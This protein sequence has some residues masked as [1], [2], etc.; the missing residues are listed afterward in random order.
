M[1]QLL[2]ESR[3]VARRH[4]RAVMAI[5][6][7]LARASMP[8]ELQRDPN[9]I[10][11]PTTVAELKALVPAFAFDAYFKALAAPAF[12]TLNVLQPDFFKALDELLKTTSMADIRAYLRWHLISVAAPYLSSAFVD[13]RFAFFGK[14]M[15]GLKE[16]QPRWKR[17]VGTVDGALGEAIGQIYVARYFPPEARARVLGMIENG[18]A[19]MRVAIQEAEWLSA[20]TKEK[21]LAKLDKTQ[22][23]IGY[24]DKWRDYTALSIDRCSYVGNVLRAR[25][26]AHRLDLDK[27]GKPVDRSQWYMTP[28]T[29]NA[30]A[31]PQSNEVA[32]PAAIL[33]PPFFDF[34]ADDAANYGGILVVILHEFGHLFDDSGANYDADGNV[35]MQWTEQDFANFMARVQLIRNQF[36]RFTVGPNNVHLKGD[37]VSGE[38]AADLNGVVLSYRALQMALAKTGRKV[39]A[40]GFTDE[41]RFFIAFGQI[42]AS[43]ST[44]E[45]AEQQAKTDPHPNEQFRVNGTLAH[46]AEFPKAFGLPDD[47]PIM[48]PPAERCHIW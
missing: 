45:Y 27:I 32:F 23:K 2:G 13:E 12:D 47:C 29:V 41:Q 44:P 6:T 3:A 35:N 9:N 7:A 15:S 26:F 21:L 16:Q 25:Q 37:L 48:L 42:W 43:I 30:Y 22:W 1:F 34:E 17:V 33:Q 31:D 18:K 39:D 10:H 38:A 28:Q 4:A 14:V 40:N 5:E 36:S 20:A 24:P 46:V 11:H 19:V 8:S